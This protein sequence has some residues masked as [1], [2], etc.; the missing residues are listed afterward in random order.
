[1][2]HCD[3]FPNCSVFRQHVLNVNAFID[4]HTRGYYS[5]GFA[6][7]VFRFDRFLFHI[8]PH[9]PLNRGILITTY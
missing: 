2:S 9:A 5:Q 1:M 8:M 4:G 6:Q 3:V 7:A